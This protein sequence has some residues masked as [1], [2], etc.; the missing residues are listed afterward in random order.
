MSRVLVVS[1]I[2]LNINKLK[3]GLER[4]KAL[5]ADTIV[6]T[7]NYFT[8][9]DGPVR[10]QKVIEFWQ[11]FLR[12][13]RDDTRIIPLLGE[14]DLNYFNLSFRTPAMNMAFNKYLNGALERNYRFVPCVAVDGVM[15]SHAGVTVNWLRENRIMLENELRFR[16]GKHGGAGLLETGIYKLKSWVPFADENS[17]LRSSMSNLITFAPPNIKQVVGHTMLNEVTNIGKIW[18]A[19]SD[20]K[21]EFIFVNNGD[22]QT[23]NDYGGDHG[24]KS[25]AES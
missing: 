10:T 16:M 23:L 19:L 6:I 15:Y 5:N 13:I 25:L 18:F 17:C 12:I 3:E 20:D 7:G 8:S 9:L 11:E 4:A 2:N 24:V 1:D 14:E 22:P 21:D